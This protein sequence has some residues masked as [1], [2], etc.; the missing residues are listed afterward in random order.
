[1][2]TPY[3]R[4]EAV[5]KAHI[6][7]EVVFKPA[8]R[9]EADVIVFEAIVIKER[10]WIGDDTDQELKLAL[11]SEIREDWGSDEGRY[12]ISATVEGLWQRIKHTILREYER[13]SK[14]CAATRRKTDEF[15]RGININDKYL[16]NY[17][18]Q[19]F[20]TINAPTFQKKSSSECEAIFEQFESLRRTYGK[21]SR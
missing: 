19:V 6:P 17:L 7:S 8:K 11:L 9:Q 10:T 3:E 21:R 1:M 12:F 5:I 18:I 14:R 20:L 16:P 15:I 4:I 2:P 13:T